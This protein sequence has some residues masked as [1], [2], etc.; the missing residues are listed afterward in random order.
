MSKNPRG[1]SGEP[2]V[3]GLGPGKAVISTDEAQ[4][5]TIW[6]LTACLLKLTGSVLEI[7][8]CLPVFSKWHGVSGVVF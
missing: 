1:L 2:D 4:K 5:N 8:R 6:R 3:P 7:P